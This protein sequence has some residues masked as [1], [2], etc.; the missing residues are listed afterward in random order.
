MILSRL[1]LVNNGLEFIN[2]KKYNMKK[3]K[4]LILC[5]LFS[6][7]F[8]KSQNSTFQI[9]WSRVDF[10]QEKW[11]VQQVFDMTAKF[12]IQDTFFISPTELKKSYQILK[13]L[14]QPDFDDYCNHM[15]KT[16]IV[17]SDFKNYF[18]G[19]KTINTIDEW[20]ELLHRNNSV[21]DS[22]NEDLYPVDEENID[23]IK[24]LENLKNRKMLIF[25]QES[26]SVFITIKNRAN[27]KKYK[28]LKR[29]K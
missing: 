12:K 8:V 13:Y 14:P 2:D 1:N 25:V 22:F 7:Q 28:H 21:F 24:L 26:G 29:L 16:F 19:I 15:Q 3:L 6:I 23:F 9:D 11:T 4:L 18:L 20:I 10:T 5:L 17:S 27:F